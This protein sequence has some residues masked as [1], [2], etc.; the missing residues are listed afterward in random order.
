LQK[1]EDALAVRGEDTSAPASALTP[2]SNK[3]KKSG[4]DVGAEE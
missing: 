3:R 1:L 4:K 2:K